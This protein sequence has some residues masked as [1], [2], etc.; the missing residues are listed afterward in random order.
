MGIQFVGIDNFYQ[1]HGS[2]NSGTGTE[3]TLFA[4]SDTI[5]PGEDVCGA[6][7]RR[8]QPSDIARLASGMIWDH[9][10]MVAFFSGFL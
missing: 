1:T 9:P 8:V 5:H 10:I 4:R 3:D 6:A 7:P 2:H